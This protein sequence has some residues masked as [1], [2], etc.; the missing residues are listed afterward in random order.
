[1]TV[2]LEVA[3]LAATRG[4]RKILD[5][6]NLCL[7]AGEVIGVVGSNGS[8][9]T[10]LLDAIG[11]LV[12]AQGEVRLAGTNTFRVPA[13]RR[14]EL[15][16]HRTFQ[17]SP[18]FPS[19]TAA[20]VRKVLRAGANG[21]NVPSQARV[22][23]LSTGMRRMLELSIAAQGEASVILLD[24]PTAGLSGAERAR[25]AQ[26]IIQWR[27]RG[28]GIVVV[29]HDR[30]F[31]ES[32]CDTIYVLE[33]GKLAPYKGETAVADKDLRRGE[34]LQPN[35]V[36]TM[37]DEAERLAIPMQPPTIPLRRL[38]R[39]GLRE[40]AA[41]MLSVL[42]LGV[43]NRIM[44][45]ELGIE[46]W[47]TAAVLATFNLTAPLAIYVGR[48]SDRRPVF[49][50]HRTPY[51]LG[52]TL[53][54]AAATVLT[55]FAALYMASAGGVR[56]GIA[57]TAVLCLMGAG[58]YA[59]GA[60]YFALL[61]DLTDAKERGRTTSVVYSMLMLGILAG[62]AMSI[63]FLSEYTASRLKLLFAAGAGVLLVLT[64]VAVSGVERRGVQPKSPDRSIESLLKPLASKQARIFFAFMVLAISFA[65]LQQAVLEPF[66]G[67][68]FS[69]SVRQTTMFNSIQIAGVLAGMA[70]GG[71]ASR[72]KSKKT[73]AG[74]GLVISSVAFLL[75]ALSGP[76]LNQPL[77]RGSIL[78]MGIGL[79]ILTVGALS[80]MMDMSTPG[81]VG[82]FMGFWTL[83]R[84]V[85]EGLATAGGGAIHGLVLGVTS[86]SVW[87]YSGVFLIEAVG[88]AFTMLLLRKVDVSTFRSEIAEQTATPA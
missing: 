65:F 56:A 39:I 11:G 58:M 41:G 34:S 66:G 79:G 35:Q 57:A 74:Y 25:V 44:K 47:L 13:R 29:E 76:L 12:P 23:E 87:A 18:M 82:M 80:L 36:T 64:Y 19:L 2:V 31:L 71:R 49:G 3:G 67:E 16:V 43:L 86:S 22:D 48:L 63:G 37:L 10:T 17:G 46:L 45:V 28:K 75:L 51:I 85:A 42:V 69:L 70:V 32:V 77:L 26:L 21:G 1:M 55:P 8:G 4:E 73:V 30:A 53:A 81:A 38:L 59:S 7:S 27:A 15:G 9:K 83:A 62:V 5:G 50:K 33:S 72:T 88:L 54:T 68:V 14:I 20:E 6:V 61:A 52:G 24:E 78:L 40:F 84:A 60:A